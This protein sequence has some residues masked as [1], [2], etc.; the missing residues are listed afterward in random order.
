MDSTWRRKYTNSVL[1]VAAGVTFLVGVWMARPAPNGEYPKAIQ[2]GLGLLLAA[3]V[4]VLGFAREAQ[5]RVSANALAS[6]REGHETL[7]GAWSSQGTPVLSRGQLIDLALR[8]ASDAGQFSRLAGEVGSDQIRRLV[9]LSRRRDEI[10]TAR[11]NISFLLVFR[12][13]VVQHADQAAVNPDHVVPPFYRPDSESQLDR[14]R[15]EI[16]RLTEDLAMQDERWRML[17]QAKGVG[18]T[19]SVTGP[20]RV[21]LATTSL[22]L[23]ENAQRFVVGMGLVYAAG[24]IHAGPSSELFGSPG[25]WVATLFML[26]ALTYVRLVTR[27]VKDD[28]HFTSESVQ[29]LPLVTLA[30]LTV[31]MDAPEFLS[32][33]EAVER[34]AKIWRDVGWWAV[35]QVEL[36][37][38]GLTW[39]DAVTGRFQLALALASTGATA[40]A[41]EL[42]ARSLSRAADHL[43]RA[44]ADPLA[45]IALARIEEDSG[46]TDAA[47]R[48]VAQSAELLERLPS[49]EP[50]EGWDRVLT[51]RDLARGSWWLWP[52]NPEAVEILEKVTGRPSD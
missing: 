43:T 31:A 6:F 1:P 3:L 16:P 15:R 4:F 21:Q 25:L 46:G 2:D 36:H 24:L 49:W 39:T 41:R 17:Q 38:P 44:G 32:H 30:Q 47:N 20:A 45:L 7:L 5:H 48:L 10:K 27:D 33:G 18:T 22:A 50:G 9:S 42:R 52:Q 13:D 14:F 12:K 51:T 11:D 40:G 37:A 23:M 34:A 19:E 28:L 8:R 35:R 29:Q 26:V